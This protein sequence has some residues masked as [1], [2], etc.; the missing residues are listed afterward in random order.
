MNINTPVEKERSI[1]YAIA[2]YRGKGMCYD[3]ITPFFIGYKTNSPTRFSGPYVR[4]CYVVH[5]IGSGEGNFIE[6]GTVHRLKKGDVFIV[7][8]HVATH[9]DFHAEDNLSFCWIGF[10]GIYAKKL[11]EL[12][13]V[14]TLK[15]D[16]FNAVKN[17][18]DNEEIMYAEPII[19]T[20]I[21]IVSEISASKSDCLLKSVKDYIDKNYSNQISIEE[22][23]KT[24]SYN[25]TYLSNLFKKQYGQSPKEY[26]INKRLSE[27]LNLILDGV[28]VYEVSNKVG[29]SNQYNFSRAF[30]LKY[31]VS[32]NNYLIKK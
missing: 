11:E 32:P 8:P 13:C 9:Y 5:V 22:I 3:E 1:E 28:K 20:I 15:G 25:R 14:H 7:K 16:Y 19:E 4:F 27:A 31:G 23:A 18:I 24:F 6:N 10:T 2:N 30:K 21:K 17:L 26:L 29:F 12:S